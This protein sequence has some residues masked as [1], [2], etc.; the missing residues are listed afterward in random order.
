MLYMCTLQDVFEDLRVKAEEAAR[1]KEEETARL[2]EKE[3]ARLKLKAQVRKYLL[4]V[5]VFKAQFIET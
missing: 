5:H 1:L 2:K 3:A 4:H